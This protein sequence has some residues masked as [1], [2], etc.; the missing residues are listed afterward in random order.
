[1]YLYIDN[2]VNFTLTRHDEG[3]DGGI[4][5]LASFGSDGF[6]E[7]VTLI[8]RELVPRVYGE[9]L[10]FTMVEYM[11]EN[12]LECKDLVK[13]YHRSQPKETQNAICEDPKLNF[14]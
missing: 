12:Q 2:L 3:G 4:V 11:K 7:A 14:T 1:L 5:A 6:K 10:G 13:A 9:V 8:S